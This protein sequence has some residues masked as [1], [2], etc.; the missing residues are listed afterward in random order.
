MTGGLES[1]EESCH[2]SK[3]AV[4]LPFQMTMRYV[5]P[6]QF[7]GAGQKPGNSHYDWTKERGQVNAS[8]TRSTNPL[9]SIVTT[10][11]LHVCRGR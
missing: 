4:R 10:L 6:V 8:Q 1:S 3:G 7:R 2:C 11:L 5:H 9:N